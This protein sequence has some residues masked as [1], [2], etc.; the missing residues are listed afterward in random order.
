MRQYM[1]SICNENYIIVEL[2][3][4]YLQE[5]ISLEPQIYAH[6]WSASLIEAE[7]EKNISVRFGILSNH[8]LIAYGFSY[9]VEDELHILNIGVDPSHQG[10][11]LGTSLIRHIISYSRERGCRK[12]YLEVRKSNSA[13]L[14]LYLSV[15]FKVTGVRPRYYS[16]NGEDAYLMERIID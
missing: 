14:Q 5:I 13:A 3:R 8:I 2:D 1:S 15:D 6:G 16:D 9:I 7:F 10:K 11:G 12:A 4:S